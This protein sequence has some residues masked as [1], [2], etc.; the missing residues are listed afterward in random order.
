MELVTDKHYA[1]VN[2]VRLIWIHL[3]MDVDSVFVWKMMDP[4]IRKVLSYTYFYAHK[5]GWYALI[6]S[7]TLLSHQPDVGSYYNTF[8]NIFHWLSAVCFQNRSTLLSNF[9]RCLLK[10]W[11]NLL[12]T[13][14]LWGNC[15]KNE[16]FYL[17]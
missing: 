15:F 5:K 2:H 13:S 6:F 4:P 7:R 10:Y 11:L 14:R 3:W 12:F 8:R 16:I 17:H 1:F 9:T